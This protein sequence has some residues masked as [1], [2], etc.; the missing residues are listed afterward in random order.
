MTERV[1]EEPTTGFLLGA[2]ASLAP[3]CSL[4]FEQTD[5][6]GCSWQY[7]PK[8]GTGPHTEAATGADFALIVE[9]EDRPARLA[10]FQ[11]KRV[12]SDKKRSFDL[13]QVRSIN[14]TKNG[15]PG[16]DVQESSPTSIPQF[17]RLL[18]H[19]IS[20]ASAAGVTEPSLKDIHWT[21]YL[22]YGKSWIRC[23]S[24]DK[25][26]RIETFY[27]STTPPVPY[28]NPGVVYM[29]RLNSRS[30]FNLLTE[31]ATP[32]HSRASLRGWLEI[33]PG[34]IDRIRD[35]LIQF[36]DVYVGRHGNGLEPSTTP[37]G[38][39]PSLPGS[40]AKEILSQ[41]LKEDDGAHSSGKPKY[42]APSNA[43]PPGP[44]PKKT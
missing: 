15:E 16:K 22:V 33:Q 31:G 5:Q 30:F 4:A 11:A 41:L 13:H 6:A 21:H 29:T 19:A 25:L 23:V 44:R 1:H 26:A 17:L 40:N 20:T 18:T 42:A 35:S 32:S 12:E 38:E 39:S 27:G 8:S 37:S 9:I 43:S 3:I 2:F 24:L 14:E 36:T 34:D 28:D 10:I 7:F